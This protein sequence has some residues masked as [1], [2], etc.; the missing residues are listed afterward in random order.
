[1]LEDGAPATIPHVPVGRTIR[2]LADPR[3]TNSPSF[4]V[5][6]AEARHVAATVAESRG[7][8]DHPDLV[9]ALRDHASGRVRLSKLQ[10]DI[11]ADQAMLVQ[12]VL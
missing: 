9:G 4:N 1:M 12:G 10:R 11:I 2:S 6:E 8:V 3:P 5:S 7:M